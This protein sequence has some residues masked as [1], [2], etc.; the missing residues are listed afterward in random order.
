L[1]DISS[2]TKKGF[3]FEETIE[4]LTNSHNDGF[5]KFIYLGN[6]ILKMDRASI[7]NSGKGVALEVTHPIYDT[8]SLNELSQ[9][10]YK[11]FF[12]QNICS[13]VVSHL[14]EAKKGEKILDMCA[15]PGGKT[16]HIANL[17]Q[18][19]GELVCCD[20]Q[21]GKVESLTKLKEKL[22]Y[23][24]MRPTVMDGTRAW[25]CVLLLVV[26]PLTLLI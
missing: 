9:N 25:T 4:E 13:M 6:G 10:Y 8:C 21:K 11:E 3:R 7:F 26:K 18:N 15:A 2:Q 23:T 1:C 17:M 12:A 24:V 16:T 22:G 14:L 5:Q 19:E 20:R